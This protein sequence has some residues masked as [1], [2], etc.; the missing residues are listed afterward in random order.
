MGGLRDKNA[1]KPLRC[2]RDG[3]PPGPARVLKAALPVLLVALGASGPA[4]GEASPSGK[5]ELARL[6]TGKMGSPTGIALDLGC[7]DA[8]LAIELAKRTGLKI[9][10]VDP[11]AD[12]VAR[13]RDAIDAAGLYGTR[14]SANR[15][16]LAKLAYP[17]YCASLIVCGDEFAGGRRGRDF[18]ELFRVLHPEGVAM[19]GQCASAA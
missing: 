7:G 4:I 6:I 3:S 18:G 14:V 9:Q 11:D 17:S 2:F 15:G 5:A 19:I 13:C 1:V 10:C 8:A 12:V 16:S